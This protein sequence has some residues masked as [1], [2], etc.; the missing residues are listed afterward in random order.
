MDFDIKKIRESYGMNQQEFA[1]AI[2]ITREMVGQ[3]ERGQKGVSKATKILIENFLSKNKVPSSNTNVLDNNNATNI[4]TSKD[5]Q[6]N[7]LIEDMLNNESFSDKEKL[8][9]MMKIYRLLEG[10]YEVLDKMYKSLVGK[11]D[12]HRGQQQAV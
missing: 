1:D 11:K 8:S 2:G 6:R 5:S 4:S 12:V 3:M 7:K 9:F 10:E